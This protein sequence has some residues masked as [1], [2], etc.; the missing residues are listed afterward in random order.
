MAFVGAAKNPGTQAPTMGQLYRYGRKTQT[1]FTCGWNTSYLQGQQKPTPVNL[2]RFGKQSIFIT[3]QNAP[4]TV[5]PNPIVQP[6]GQVSNQQAT[7]N[8][9]QQTA[10]A[11]MVQADSNTSLSQQSGNTPQIVMAGR[12]GCPFVNRAHDQHVLQK[13]AVLEL[14]CVHPKIKDHPVCQQNMQA[15]RGTPAY[16]RQTGP[17]SYEHIHTGFTEDLS[18]ME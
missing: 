9:R 2:T 7:N 10:N 14:N 1:Q 12:N 5:F 13:K 17:N 18:F 6:N 15:K 11:P 3:P 16:Y 8:H 4:Q